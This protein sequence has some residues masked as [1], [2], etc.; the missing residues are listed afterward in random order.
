[1]AKALAMAWVL[2]TAPALAL[3]TLEP[4]WLWQQARQWA[5]AQALERPGQALGRAAGV[6]HALV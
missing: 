6:V 3:Q 4:V 5:M 2:V 1:M